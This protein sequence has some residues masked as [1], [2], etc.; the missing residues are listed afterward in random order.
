[1]YVYLYMYLYEYVWICINMYMY[2]YFFEERGSSGKIYMYICICMYTSLKKEDSAS[3]LTTLSVHSIPSLG[4]P[5]VSCKYI[6]GC[7]W[8]YRCVS[9]CI[10][11]YM[12]EERCICVCI[13]ICI[14]M[15]LWIKGILRLHQPPSHFLLLEIQWWVI[16]G[17]IS[18]YMCVFIYMNMYIYIYMIL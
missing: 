5:M 11:T 6:Q 12:D 9:I 4:D 2:I 3:T 8:M 17:C 13:Y 15:L 14:Y 18:M 1:M 10:Y 16:Q 7:I